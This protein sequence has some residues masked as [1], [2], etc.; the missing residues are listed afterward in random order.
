MSAN[1]KDLGAGALFVFVGAVYG[2][3]AWFGLP[4]GVA[5]N[6]GPGYFP[7]VLSGILIILGLA[8]VR[9]GF[10]DVEGR[11]P[12]GAVPWRGVVLLSLATVLF[13]AFSEKLGLLP[14]VF[15]TAFISTLSNPKVRILNSL[16]SSICIALFCTAVF[17]YG[18]RLPM[19]VIGPWLR[20]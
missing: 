19:P 9:R 12:F 11:A 2:S 6:M 13:A 18:I 17:G 20:F 15:L 3:I 10:I 16:V 1:L 4:I 14:A 7:V 5:L 8:I